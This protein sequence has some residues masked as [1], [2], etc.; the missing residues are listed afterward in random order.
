MISGKVTRIERIENNGFPHIAIFVDFYEDDVL[1]YQDWILHAKWD[2]FDQV[3]DEEI[4]TWVQKN[5]EAQ[6]DN[7]IK[8]KFIALRE[9]QIIQAKLKNLIG[10]E[11]QKETADINAMVG[12][13]DSI[14]KK[15]TVKADGTFT[16]VDVA[17]VAPAQGI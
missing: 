6:C 5:I 13:T 11:Y 15:F 3:P 4:N 1:F 10:T 17:S 2:N 8:A 12:I 14:N 7:F 16:V 9:P